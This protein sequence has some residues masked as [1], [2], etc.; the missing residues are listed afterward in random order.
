MTMRLKS[1]QQRLYLAIA[2]EVRCF[3][4]ICA[5]DEALWVSDLP[6]RT[7]QYGE[8]VKSLEALGFSCRIDVEKQLCYVDWTQEKWQELFKAEPAHIPPLPRAQRY[9]EAYALCRL[10]LLHPAEQTRENL[11]P[12]RRLLKRMEE[13]E[14]R[15]LDEI[16]F[17]YRE[18]AVRL[19][20]GKPAAYD[21]GRLLAGWLMERSEKE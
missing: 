21:A 8:I 7:E 17:F 13:P 19:R 15:L 2:Q 14:Q 9:H 16:G 1:E 4:H 11:A 5:E 12:V 3:V 20:E 6:R 10:W 18:A